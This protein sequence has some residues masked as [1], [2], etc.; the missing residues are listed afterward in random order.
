MIA[1]G[2]SDDKSRNSHIYPYN[3][4]IFFCTLSI[5]SWIVWLLWKSQEVCPSVLKEFAYPRLENFLLTSIEE[6]GL[7]IAPQG[8]P[9]HLFVPCFQ[10]NSDW[11]FLR[12]GENK[13]LQP[14]WCFQNYRL[15]N[16][17]RGLVP[18]TGWYILIL[19]WMGNLL[20]W[21]TAYG[22]SV[23][24]ESFNILSRMDASVLLADLVS[25]PVV[26]Q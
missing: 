3:I 13:I 25:S 8:L 23:D 4:P 10:S 9:S 19:L 22:L 18:N 24:C 1:N 6:L 11:I 17:M 21:K 20:W 16:F 2:R 26:W 15:E 5:R 7:V 12:G 14:K